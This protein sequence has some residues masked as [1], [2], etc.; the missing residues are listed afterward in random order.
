MTTLTPSPRM[1]RRRLAVA[2]A[3][4]ILL[5]LGFPPY[6]LWLLVPV[7]VGLLTAACADVRGRQGAV[8]GLV[9]GVG[10]FGLLLEWI[11][12]VG[13]DAWVGLTLLEASFW[14][15][16]GF[17][18]AVTARLGAW[19]LWA[20]GV[21]VL[22]EALRS[23]FPFGGFPWGRLAFGTVDSPYAAF[24]SVAGAAGVTAVVAATGVLLA[25]GS[26][27][28]RERRV[29]GSAQGGR[30][31]A[32]L[33]AGVAGLLVAGLLA[34]AALVHTLVVQ[35]RVTGSSD[36]AGSATFA[37][38]QGNVPRLGL[39]FLGQRQQVLQNHVDA[40]LALAADVEQGR[41]PAPDVVVWP[42]NSSDIDP[43]ADPT[44]AALIDEAVQTVGAPTLVGALVASE[45]GTEVENSGIVWDP[46]DGSGDRY[47]KRHPVPFGEYIPFREQLAP[48]VGRLDLVPRDFAAGDE[49]GLLQLGPVLVGDVICFE[50]AYDLEVRDVVVGGAQV[51]V[52]QTNNATYGRTGQP[53][54]QFAISRLRAI[55][56]GIPVLVAATSGVSGVIEADGTVRVR[57]AE[58]TQDVVVE[59]VA[60][61]VGGGSAWTGL[62]PWVEGALAL[63]GGL[64]VV[65]GTVWG[66]RA[67]R[68]GRGALKEDASLD[69]DIHQRASP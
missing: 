48:L 33:R 18:L 24:A 40:T 59:E 26:V 25:A 47:V 27:A 61:R 68:P 20:A 21:W 51:V 12:V 63:L 15:L 35:P 14:L 3:A 62:V 36:A 5:A 9:A 32:G 28:L 6:D 30:L 22:V 19:P 38:V 60:L 11:R 45:D 42:E 2:L 34:S 13:V 67:A 17:G 50:I 53:D 56:H 39:D 65:L 54:Q 52:V 41:A 1:S 66:R 37:L 43:F 46:E 16:L 8:L 7:G 44:A 64:G 4:G 49:P 23:R 57:T 29:A 69:A 58:F 10:F 55:E 31:G